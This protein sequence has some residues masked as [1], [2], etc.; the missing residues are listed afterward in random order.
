MSS[1]EP[2]PTQRVSEIAP[3]P[4]EGRWL[5]HSVCAV[6][7]V[8]VIGGAAKSAKTWMGLDLAVSVASATPCLG[9]FAVEQPGPVLA[10]LAEDS[11][12]MARQRVEGI[13][14]VRGI[15]LASLELHLITAPT[16][17]L[18]VATD[19]ERLSATVDALE[20][21]LLLLDPLVRMH[22]ANENDSR[23]ISHLLA[24]LR[25]LQRLHDLAITLVHHTRKNGSGPAGLSLR[26]SSDIYAW[27]DSFAYLQRRNDGY[28]LQ[29]EH[30]FERPPQPV[31][32]RLACEP[33]G[34]SPR[35]EIDPEASVLPDQRQ[36]GLL[37][38]AVLRELVAAAEPLTRT[39]L[40]SRLQVNNLRLGNALGELSSSGRIVRTSDGWL[41]GPGDRSVPTHSDRSERNDP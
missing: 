38:E 28:L 18:D 26:G 22:D 5:I 40:R 41:P 13:C 36:A 16:L 39:S 27:L 7:T 23:E 12:E 15:P 32:L 10:Y 11:L 21:R 14:R 19:L 35:L 8:S 30:R 20:P 37:S 4:V 3:S 9:V 1:I 34:T 2:L 29:L 24:G 33:D 31:S 6:S 17:R 25:S